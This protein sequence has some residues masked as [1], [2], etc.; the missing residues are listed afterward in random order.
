M[1]DLARAKIK[2]ITRDIGYQGTRILFDEA[3]RLTRTGRI[4]EARQLISDAEELRKR[5]KL[6][7]PFVLSRMV[8]KNCGVPLIPGLT[9]TYR[10]R[11]DGRVTRLVV[12]CDI[13][14][15]KRRFVLRIRGRRDGPESKKAKGDSPAKKS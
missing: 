9:A 12:T 15:Y 10:L 11:R 4:E 8:C 1:F 2:D 13:C 5:I 6:R 14:G 7:K 3:V